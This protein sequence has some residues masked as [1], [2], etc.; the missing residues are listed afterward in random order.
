MYSEAVG[1]CADAISRSYPG[2][3]QAAVM[4]NM[5]CKRLMP[6][7]GPEYIGKPSDKTDGLLLL[8]F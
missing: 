6:L 8:T 5:I 3:E 4:L 2:P 7:A 1:L